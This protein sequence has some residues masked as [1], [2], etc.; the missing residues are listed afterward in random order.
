[1]VM[2]FADDAGGEDAFSGA[3]GILLL[4]KGEHLHSGVIIVDEIT[5]CG[6]CNQRI[7]DRRQ[8]Q[9]RSIYNIPLGGCRHRIVQI[10][11]Q[12]FKPEHRFARKDYTSAACARKR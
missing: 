4:Q 8:G 10:F 5:L 3:V 1:M 12:L 7:I 9:C 6:K 11:L 2:P